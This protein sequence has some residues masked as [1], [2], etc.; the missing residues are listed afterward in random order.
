MKLI[1]KVIIE[2]PMYWAV[3]VAIYDKQYCYL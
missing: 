2:V 1:V 3:L